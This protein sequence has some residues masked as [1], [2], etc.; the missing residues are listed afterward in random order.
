MESSLASWGHVPGH[1][2]AIG[3]GGPGARFR[4]MRSPRELRR[5]VTAALA[6]AL[7]MLATLSPAPVQA[8]VVVPSTIS[9]MT[10][11]IEYGGTVV[12]LD[13]ILAAVRRA[14]AD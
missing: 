11:N 6:S 2:E 9:I 7:M 5:P 1:R 13:K 3:P 12:D 14:D 4:A 8:G 10:F